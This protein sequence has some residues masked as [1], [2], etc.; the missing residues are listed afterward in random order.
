MQVKYLAIVGLICGLLLAFCYLIIAYQGASASISGNVDKGASV[1][2][3]ALNQLFGQGG[4]IVLGLI[5]TLACLSVCIGLITSCAQY[6]SSV[7]PKISYIQW[8]IL[9]CII[10]GFVANLG[11]SQILK[12]SVPVLGLVYPLAI[13]LIILGLLHD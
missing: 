6:F 13:T 12:V 4:T 8:T 11:L 9:L 5:F 7:F 1:L 10:S 3:A 2:S